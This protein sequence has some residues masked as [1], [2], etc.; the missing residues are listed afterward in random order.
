MQQHDETEHA[1]ERAP[2]ARRQTSP[3]LGEA[4]SIKHGG[5]VGHVCPLPCEKEFAG[6]RKLPRPPP[7]RN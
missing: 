6:N 5:R 2:V 1:A 7:Y 3:E 4:G